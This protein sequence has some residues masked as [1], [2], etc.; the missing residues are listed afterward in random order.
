MTSRTLQGCTRSALMQAKGKIEV[1]F[2][3]STGDPVTPAAT[4]VRSAAKGFPE[5]NII[6]EQQ[7]AGWEVGTSGRAGNAGTAAGPLV[8]ILGYMHLACTC[9]C[10]RLC[11]SEDGE[12][13][14]VAGTRIMEQ[15]PA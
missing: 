1:R 6:A 3:S 2:S 14:K 13:T 11:S 4:A 7:R 5:I 9:I 8:P 10:R 15:M 12:F